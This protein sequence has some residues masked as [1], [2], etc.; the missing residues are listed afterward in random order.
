M[1]DLETRIGTWGRTSRDAHRLVQRSRGLGWAITD[2]QWEIAPVTK[3]EASAAE[4]EQAVVAMVPSAVINLA[5]A[6]KHP[7]IGGDQASGAEAGSAGVEGEVEVVVGA[8]AADEEVAA[9]E[10]AEAGDGDV[11]VRVSNAADAEL[12]VTR[13]TSDV[14]FPRSH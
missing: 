10:E 13:R 12:D 14:Q 8:V 5:D 1:P 7:A 11:S 2:Q 9:G 6:L 4:R 3:R